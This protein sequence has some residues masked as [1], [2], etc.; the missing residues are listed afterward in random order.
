MHD[1]DWGLPAPEGKLEPRMLDLDRFLPQYEAYFAAG[2]GPTDGDLIWPAMPPRAVPWLEGIL[3]CTVEYSLPTS[4]IFAEAVIGDGWG[5]VPA[6]L[7]LAANPWFLKLAEFILGLSKL[8][9]GR[10]AVAPPLTRGPWDLAC[11]LRGMGNAYLDLYDNPDELRK[12]GAFCRRVWIEVTRALAEIVP[13]WRGGVVGFLGMWAPGFNP[14]PQNDASVSVSPKK[15]RE[16]MREADQ[17][18]AEAWECQIFH[19]HSAGLQ[20]VDDVLP[21][22]GGRALNVVIDPAG[23]SLEALLPT[24]RHVQE[25]NVPL[26]LGLGHR[27]QVEP[28]TRALEP[29]GLAITYAPGDQASAA[30]R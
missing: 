28:I 1:F 25:A 4:S 20:I 23:P 13:R 26:H 6:P 19:L 21:F 2:N 18:V 22:L 5:E 16:V 7:P 3:G 24:L 15:Y 29:A 10:F 27:D 12:L 14:L 11:A 9:S 30:G 8:S 17:E